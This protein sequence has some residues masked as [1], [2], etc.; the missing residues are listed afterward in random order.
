MKRLILLGGGHAHVHVL[1]ALG[2][3]PIPDCEVVLV[4]P[5]E[6]QIYSGMLPGWIAGHYTIEACALSLPQLAS[7][8][9][10]RF[11]HAAGESLDADGHQLTCNDGSRLDFDLLSIDT[12]SRSRIETIAGATEHA[13]PVRPI[14]TFISG[15]EALLARCREARDQPVA[16]IGGGVAAVELAFAIHHRL[17]R[18]GHSRVA[19][20][21]IGDAGLPLDGLASSLQWKCL[22]LLNERGIHWHAGSRV[23]ELTGQHAVL[24][25]GTRIPAGH[26]LL[27]TGAGAS[28]WPRASGLAVDDAGFIRVASSLESISHRGIFAAGDIAAYADPRPKSGVYA[29]RAGPPLA[30]NLRRAAQGEP[31][32]AWKPQRRALYLIATGDRHALGAW[33]PFGWWGDWVWRW[34]DRIDRAFMRRFGNPH[35]G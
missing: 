33:G 20:Q 26:A 10:V 23:V 15:V 5:F 32:A 1:E 27:V 16:I 7:R 21:V 25:D 31:L 2:R 34:K 4:S 12:G 30:A 3:E 11:V 19:L 29:V 35:V 17:S 18:E 13:L 22:E 14:E 9:G 8:A 28:D 24:D 6:R